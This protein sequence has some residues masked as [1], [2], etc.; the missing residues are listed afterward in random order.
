MRVSS[1]R[2]ITLSLA[3]L[4][5][6]AIPVAVPRAARSPH[7]APNP[8]TAGAATLDQQTELA[9]TVYNSN[10]ALVRDVR[11]VDLPG[12]VSDL[13]FEDIAAT[14][15]A[16][17]VHFRSLTEPSLVRVLEQNYRFDLLDPERLLRKY[18]GRDV[19]LVRPRIENDAT[20]YEEVTARLLAYNQ[21]P[22]WR[23]GHEI[24]TGMSYESIRFPEIP[25]TLHS[26]PTLVWTLDNRGASR[27]RIETS[28]LAG[29]M[30]WNAD[31]VLTVG[32]DDAHADLDGWV[33]VTNTSGTSFRKARLQ[34]VAGDLHRVENLQELKDVAL[35]KAAAAPMSEDAFAREVFSEYHLYT[36]GRPTTLQE[37]E[38]KQISML[39]GTGIPVQKA[40]VVNGQQFYYRNRQSP[41]SPIKDDVRVFY[42]F[43]NDDPSG[44]GQPLPA[45][46]MRVYQADTKGS[47][48][49]AGEDRID[50]TPKDEALTLDIG[51]AFDVVCERKQTDFARNRGQRLRDGL[52]DHASQPQ[53]ERNHRRGERADCRRLA[54]AP[55]HL[56]GHEDR[57]V[58]RPLFRSGGGRRHERVALSGQ[59]E[60]V[61]GCG[62][63]RRCTR[64][65]ITASNRPPRACPTRCCRGDPRHELPPPGRRRARPAADHGRA[66]RR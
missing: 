33:T 50:H 45:G 55:V 30:N 62:P 38:T 22:V 24:V 20:R 8:D 5:V 65:H 39:S 35:R 47:L 43:K 54:D 26:R 42:R 6:A 17:T 31:Y 66:V 57:G 48:Q 61:T 41:G 9:V 25:E 58:R 60:L 44:L 34:L 53:G 56:R 21:A 36:L 32:R 15:N 64:W 28:Y 13:Q 10:I 7:V 63:E 2:S 59:G 12:G 1:R 29:G 40:F 3:V 37:N 23:I 46:T 16:T 51:K 14:V 4:I 52:R 11:Q 27:H 18:I 49:F 19:T